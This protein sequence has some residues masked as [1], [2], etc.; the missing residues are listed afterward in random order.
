[1]G[2]LQS[3]LWDYETHRIALARLLTWIP[4][5]PSVPESFVS[6]SPM[7]TS[8][9]SRRLNWQRIS[10]FMRRPSSDWS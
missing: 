10:K 4:E 8:L 2:L 5:R 3:A 7:I 6:R 9:G 1:M